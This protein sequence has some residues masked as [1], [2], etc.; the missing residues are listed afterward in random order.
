M[1]QIQLEDFENYQVMYLKGSFTGED[2][3]IDSLR[4]TF[5]KIA[6]P[7]KNKLLIDLSELIYLTTP[8]I[9]VLLSGNS[10]FKKVGGKVVM[11]N[12]IEYIEN[13]FNITKLTLTIPYFETLEEAIEELEKD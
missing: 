13:I 2:K 4:S 1:T 6:K 7:D 10:L 11:Y 8:A 3:E 5:K 9:G 12:A